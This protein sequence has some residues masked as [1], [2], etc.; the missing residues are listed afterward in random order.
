MRVELGA[1]VFAARDDGEKIACLPAMHAFNTSSHL[2]FLG[3]NPS[4]SILAYGDRVC[5][6]VSREGYGKARKSTAVAASGLRLIVPP[7][8]MV[9]SSIGRS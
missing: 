3:E 1:L 6:G 4:I 7:A 8:D 2:I 9:L 5:H